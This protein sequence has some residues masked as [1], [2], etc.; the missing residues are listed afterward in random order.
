MNR[1]NKLQNQQMDIEAEKAANTAN[2]V[3]GVA[4]T[5]ANIAATIDSG[6]GG[7]KNAPFNVDF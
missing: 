4:G 5:A 3:A 6:A 7:V 1:K 2:A